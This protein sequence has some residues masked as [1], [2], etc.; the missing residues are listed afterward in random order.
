MKK[1]T[2][3]PFPDKGV[4]PWIFGTGNPT[5]PSNFPNLCVPFTAGFSFCPS[6]YNAKLEDIVEWVYDFD[7][8]KNTF[9][10]FAGR[11]RKLEPIPLALCNKLCPKDGNYTAYIGGPEDS[12]GVKEPLLPPPILTVLP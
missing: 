5:V 7:D 9:G 12:N 11:T 8:P 1:A 2:T 3:M 10:W 6:I 4:A